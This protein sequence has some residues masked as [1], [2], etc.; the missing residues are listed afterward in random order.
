MCAFKFEIGAN[1]RPM[2]GDVLLITDHLFGEDNNGRIR[3]RGIGV[4]I[5]RE[6]KLESHVPQRVV[7]IFSKRYLLQTDQ[8]IGWVYESLLEHPI[9]EGT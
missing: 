2:W 8:G 3:F 9:K 6:L 4:V 1:V 5:Y 7:D